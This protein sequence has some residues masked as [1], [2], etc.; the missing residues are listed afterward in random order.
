MKVIWGSCQCRYSYFFISSMRISWLEWLENEFLSVWRSKSFE[1]SYYIGTNIF[2]FP[3]E[4]TLVWMVSKWDP[5]CLK[6]KVIQVLIQIRITHIL[7]FQII[8][9]SFTRAWDPLVNVFLLKN[10]Y[11]G[12]VKLF[13]YIYLTFYKESS[14]NKLQWCVE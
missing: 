5:R 13:L 8:P 12:G 3:Y 6:M 9:S 10:I 2:S 14:I 7:S 4:N 1:S 11:R